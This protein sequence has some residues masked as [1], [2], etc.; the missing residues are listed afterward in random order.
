MKQFLFLSFL[1]ANVFC[2]QNINDFVVSVQ[3]DNQDIKTLQKDIAAS[4]QDKV[5]AGKL[6]NPILSGYIGNI[7][8]NQ[9][10]VRNIDASQQINIGLMQN[11][12]ISGRLSKQ[13]KAEGYKIYALNKKLEQKKLDIEYSVKEQ[14]Y[15]IA[16]IEAKKKIF[17]KY[18]AN[19]KLLLGILNANLVSGTASHLAIVKAE[20]EEQNI[21]N[22]LYK[23]D[24]DLQSAKAK[25][26]SI[27]NSKNLELPNVSLA[28]ENIQAAKFNF[29]KNAL[30]EQKNYEVQTAEA[31]Y[32]VEKAKYLPDIGVNIGYS[33]ADP[34][35]RN[36]AFFGLSIP[37]PIYGREAASSAKALAQKASKEN[38]MQ[39]AKNDLSAE[40]ATLKS[41]YENIKKSY[42][43]YTKLSK[44]IGAHG[45]DLI[46]NEIK[47]SKASQ[48]NAV[49]T[50]NEILGFEIKL[51]DIKADSMLISANLKR[52]NGEAQ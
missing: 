9:P 31:L 1:C 42:E 34:A 52:I 2:V 22:E 41:R 8:T 20:I 5:L 49:S 24:I 33:F 32:K 19:Y 6:D 11:I 46:L 13:E 3:N 47:S 29:D 37:L 10:L 51:V 50:I 23:L 35:Y 18:L 48:E 12:P 36:Y 40:I 25:L 28:F 15:T 38:E 7:I 44:T 30:I 4:E 16:A 39:G 26:N 21:K 45:L 17:D 43:L 27:A 14:L